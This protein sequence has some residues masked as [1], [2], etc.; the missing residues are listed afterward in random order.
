MAAQITSDAP[1]GLVGAQLPGANKGVRKA[2]P[3]DCGPK[4]MLLRVFQGVLFNGR[5]RPVGRCP[6]CRTTCQLPSWP[7]ASVACY[8]QGN[9][10]PCFSQEAMEALDCNVGTSHAWP[11]CFGPS[12]EWSAW[13]HARRSSPRTHSPR[14]LQNHQWGLTNSAATHRYSRCKIMRQE[15]GQHLP[16][17]A[18]LQ[19]SGLGCIWVAI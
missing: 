10:C 18:G 12:P 6:A 3:S 5:P 19:A 1:P 8:S 9:E 16:R 11:C 17:H 13:R 2:V 4:L 15:P 14:L 7:P